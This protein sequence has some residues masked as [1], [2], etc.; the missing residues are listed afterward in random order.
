M[1]LLTGVTGTVGRLVAER[2]RAPLAAPVA[3]GSG[4]VPATA[5]EPRPLR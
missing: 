2:L 4:S 5:S 3:S 1:I